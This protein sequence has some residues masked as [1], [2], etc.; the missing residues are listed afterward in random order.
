MKRENWHTI[1]EMVHYY[2]IIREN[3]VVRNAT[4]NRYGEVQMKNA[5]VSELPFLG[6]G[7]HTVN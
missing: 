1:R 6:T 2:N 5:A 4:K 7:T 3:A